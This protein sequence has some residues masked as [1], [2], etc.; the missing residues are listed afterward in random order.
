MPL[1]FVI[2][3]DQR[4]SM[5]QEELSDLYKKNSYVRVEYYIK[6]PRTPK[7]NNALHTF[8]DSIAVKCN[9]AGYWYEIT[10]PVL[11][12][13]IELPWTKENVKSH[14]WKPVQRALYPGTSSSKDLSTKELSVVA[15]AL[16]TWLA[17][18]HKLNVYFPKEDV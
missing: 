6:P 13:R 7:Q 1:G 3:T 12:S 9:N 17:D 2:N 18:K 16:A 10:S 14:M 15:E 8:C 5:F 11:K 4:L